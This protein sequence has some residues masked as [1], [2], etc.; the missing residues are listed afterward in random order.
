MWAPKL[1]APPHN[2]VGLQI[3]RLGFRIAVLDP[4]L[5]QLG[6]QLGYE[7]HNCEFVHFAAEFG[8]AGV[9]YN[10]DGAILEQSFVILNSNMVI[11]DYVI[12]NNDLLKPNHIILKPNFTILVSNVANMKPINAILQSI[13]AILAHPAYFSTQL[14]SFNPNPHGLLNVLFSLGWNSF[15]QCF[16]N[17]SIWTTILTKLYI[18]QVSDDEEMYLVFLLW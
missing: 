1:V 15:C 14:D 2:W 16:R 10:H 6:S 4:Q 3:T 17:H 18:M 5:V 13:V 7:W 9:Q 8:S 11:F 12:F